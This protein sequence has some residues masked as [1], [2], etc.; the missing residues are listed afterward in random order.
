[1]VLA[2]QSV[3]PYR[4]SGWL[5]SVGAACLQPVSSVQTALRCIS[6]KEKKGFTGGDSGR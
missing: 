2:Y 1:M 3:Q 6:I 5:D 4:R